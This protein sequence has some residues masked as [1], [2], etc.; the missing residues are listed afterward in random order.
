MAATNYQITA[1]GDLHVIHNGLALHAG[2]LVQLDS[3]AAATQV[4]LKA[5]YITSTIT[6]ATLYD[7]GLQ[8][9]QTYTVQAAGNGRITHNLVVNATGN[10]I[11]LDPLYPQ[12]I[13]LVARGLIA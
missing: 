12:T 13:S 7:D 2:R 1:A 11:A 3:A 9:L 8:P 5:V 10:T 4:A 6:T